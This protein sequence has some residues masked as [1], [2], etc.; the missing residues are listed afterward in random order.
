MTRT[1]PTIVDAHVHLWNPERLHYAWL[2][3]LPEL[4]RPMLPADLQAASA[5]AGVGKFIF[6][7]SGC[8]PAQSLAEADWIAGL[9]EAEP[10][11][12]GIIAHAP[13]E[14]G[15]A[16][17]ADLELLGVRPLVKGVRRNLQAETDDFFKRP[18]F[19]EGLKL[20]PEFGFTFDLC[21]RAGQLPAACELARRA[22]QVSFV[23][24]HFGKPAVREKDHAPWARHLRTLAGLPNVVC[25]ISGL[26]TEANWSDW[27]AADLEPYFDHASD[28]LA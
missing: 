1:V 12:K 13:V 2:D 3:G 24:D 17:R 22:P 8:D 21:I 4:N 5:S 28:C 25:K 15:E 19:F 16:V 20:L 9:A 18:Q 27:R 10:R 11:L 14:R 7:E 6:V 26:T 23:L